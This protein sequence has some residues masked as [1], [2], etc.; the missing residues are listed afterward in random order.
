MNEIYKNRL[1]ELI[2]KEDVILFAGAGL[3]LYAGYPSGNELRD[4][5]WKRLNEIEKQNFDK[6]LQLSILTQNIF[7]L[8]GSR[9]S[10]ISTL[11]DVFLTKPKKI[12]LI[13]LSQKYH[14]SR[15]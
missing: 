11:R 1:F 7:D 3:S 15:Q 10:I 8:H 5:F 9:N 6:N 2:S 12:K 4:I 13:R 14:I